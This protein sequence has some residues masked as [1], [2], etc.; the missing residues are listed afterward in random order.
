M[1]KPPFDPNAAAAADSGIFGLPDRASDAR[2]HL[3]PVPFEATTSYGG[4][5][6]RGPA[7]ILAASRQVDLFDVDHGRAYEEG[8]FMLD[9]PRGVA[10][11]D[12]VARRDAKAIIDVG[13]DLGG[14]P[15]LARALQKV[16]DA[17]E[18]L[19]QLVYAASQAALAEGR[20]LG[21]VGGD[22]SVPFGAIQ[23]VAEKHPGMGV[24]HFDAHADLRIA[25][26]GF[27]WSHASIMY[28]VHTR[29]PGVKRIVQVGIR[30][31]CE[32]E[33]D[34]IKASRG[35]IKTWFDRDVARR[36]FGGE[37]FAK[38]AAA[39]VRDLPAKVYVSFDIDGLDPVLCPHTG[40][41]VP[42]GLSFN[43]AVFLLDAVAS[44]GKTIVGFDLCEVTPG[45][46]EWDANVGARIL[47]QLASFM[48][49]TQRRSRR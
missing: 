17:G 21:V 42:G 43:E 37:S 27:T 44:A 10:A 7:A 47:F 35:R 30:D 9:P 11:L 8:I 48:L 29:I 25:Y 36:R 40:T 24:L 18:R 38:I 3:L 31:V 19:N 33:I 46:D 6:S 45:P 41:P 34:C 39:I 15:A 22:H 14:K 49:R 16:N 1:P 4:G 23:A 2:V 5:T 20:L 13:G 12:R 32:Q 26:E 28:N